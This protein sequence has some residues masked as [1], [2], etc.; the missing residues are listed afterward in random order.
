[1][2]PGIAN[3]NSNFLVH[4]HAAKISSEAQQTQNTQL[5]MEIVRMALEKSTQY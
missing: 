2:A 4:E 5:T 3:G 1:V